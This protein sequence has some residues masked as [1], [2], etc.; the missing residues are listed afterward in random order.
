MGII[1]KKRLFLTG[2]F[3]LTAAGCL[4]FFLYACSTAPPPQ[5]PPGSP[6]PYRVMGKWY[7]PIPDARGFRQHGTA[8]WYGDDFHGKRT[9]SGEIYDMNALTAAHKTLPLGTMVGVKHLENGREIKVRINDR[10][11]FVR[12]RVI[13]LS[14]RAAKEI[15]IFN[16]GTGPVEIVALG[17]PE[18]GVGAPPQTGSYAASNSFSG[19]FTIQVGAFSDRP[20]AERLAQ[21]LSKTYKNVHISE[22][23]DGRTTFYRI[24]LGRTHDLEEANQYEAYLIENG[25]TQAF[26]VAE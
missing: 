20:N 13:D 5:A 10:G 7:Q 23:F 25:F 21:S 4:A 24:R 16:S 18:L 11:P 3:I 22:Y 14:A 15:E 12:D 26:V 2:F 9:S 6:R 1:L 8:S 19:N 17:N